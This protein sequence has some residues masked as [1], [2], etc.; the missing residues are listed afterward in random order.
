MMC[1]SRWTIDRVCVLRRGGSGHL[2]SMGTNRGTQKNIDINME[3]EWQ[4]MGKK[5]RKSK[6]VGM[7]IERKE[8]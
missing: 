7:C 3:K 5:S 8:R 1:P 2:E 4:E 6:M